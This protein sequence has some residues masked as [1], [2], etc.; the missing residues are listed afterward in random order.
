[1]PESKEYPIINKGEITD[2]QRD[3]GAALINVVSD[4]ERLV[5]TVGSDDPDAA[6]EEAEGLLNSIVIR[7][8]TDF[9]T[10]LQQGAENR[11]RKK[12][13]E[14]KKKREEPF[15]PP[16]S[17]PG[18]S[19]LSS[20]DSCTSDDQSLET[21][22]T[23]YRA[24]CGLFDKIIGTRRGKV[25]SDSFLLIYPHHLTKLEKFGFFNGEKGEP[26]PESEPCR[27]NLK[28]LIGRDPM[29]VLV[30]FDED[31]KVRNYFIEK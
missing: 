27:L 13:V 9:N 17:P 5:E 23:D 30:W 18:S 20:K 19:A 12:N 2:F 4:L 29:S 11:E 26:E 8:N 10:L 24:V 21:K 16:P 3:F 14:K 25:K 7:F 28:F 22:G 15:S 31:N 6:C 1:M